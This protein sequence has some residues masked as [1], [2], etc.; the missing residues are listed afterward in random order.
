MIS[1][2]SWVTITWPCSENIVFNFK[3]LFLIMFS[4]NVV[5]SILEMSI[6]KVF[7]LSLIT[8]VNPFKWDLLIGREKVAAVISVTPTNVLQWNNSDN[9]FYIILYTHIPKS[10]DA[11]IIFNW[12]LTC[13][14]KSKWKVLVLSLILFTKC[15]FN[16]IGIT[17]CKV[18]H[19]FNHCSPFLLI[20][21]SFSIIN[22]QN[23][24]S[25]LIW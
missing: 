1:L 11:I 16:E 15:W 2:R 23:H 4:L 3:N 10:L 24:S 22:F 19:I 6:I 21:S 5:H 13:N 7:V 14:H 18:W 25:F 12:C 9:S 20:N 17:V 8:N